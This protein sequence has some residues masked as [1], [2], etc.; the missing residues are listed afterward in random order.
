L[1]ECWG[2]AVVVLENRNSMG[3]HVRA[4]LVLHTGATGDFSTSH[5]PTGR[6]AAAGGDKGPEVRCV[7]LRCVRQ[8]GRQRAGGASFCLFLL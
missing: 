7:A 3:Y 8:A 2:A 4:R 5:K 6:A 1:Y